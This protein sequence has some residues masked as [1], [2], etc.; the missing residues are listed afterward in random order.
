MDT[1]TSLSSN[2]PGARIRWAEPR[3]GTIKIAG[4]L[5]IE[6]ACELRQILSEILTR[7]SHLPPDFSQGTLQ[8]DLADVEVCGTPGVQLLLSAHKT[9]ASKRLPIRFVA[10]SPAVESAFSRFGL[11]GIF[12]QNSQP[13]D[14]PQC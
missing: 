3:P 7:Q 11:E 1:I 5:H 4:I 6:T 8:V 9:A 13:G 14:Q 12:F 2:E 10:P